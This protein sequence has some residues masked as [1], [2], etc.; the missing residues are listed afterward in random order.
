MRAVG[1]RDCLSGTV[2]SVRAGRMSKQAMHESPRCI[3]RAYLLRRAVYP[4]YHDPH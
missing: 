1:I 4:P 3:A 2:I